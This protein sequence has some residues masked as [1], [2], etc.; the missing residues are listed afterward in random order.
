MEPAGA[1]RIF[2]QANKVEISA[3][4]RRFAGENV[5]GGFIGSIVDDDK[6]ADRVSLGVNRLKASF[7][8]RRTVSRYD[9]CRY[10]NQERKSLI[11]KSQ[12]NTVPSGLI[13]FRRPR[14]WREDDH[15]AGSLV[16]HEGPLA[17]P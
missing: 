12:W 8:E 13:F 16:K 14:D 9:D 3:A 1:A 4:A 15:G 11:Y 6:L 10:S 17:A 7:K 5:L 2:L